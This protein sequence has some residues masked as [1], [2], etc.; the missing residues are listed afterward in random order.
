MTPKREELLFEAMT[1]SIA[2]TS[3]ILRMLVQRFGYE[4]GESG[5]PSDTLDDIARDMRSELATPSDTPTP[6]PQGLS[7]TIDEE[8]ELWTPDRH[9]LKTVPDPGE[10]WLVERAEDEAEANANNDAFRRDAHRGET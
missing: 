5:N 9:G 3:K 2:T 4:A 1:M 6:Q 7:L 10:Y 8:G